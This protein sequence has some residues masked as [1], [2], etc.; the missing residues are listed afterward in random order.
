MFPTKRKAPRAVPDQNQK[1]KTRESYV[2][3]PTW[4]FTNQ[5]PCLRSSEKGRLFG[6]TLILTGGLIAAVLGGPSEAS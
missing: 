4:D 2:I 1:A 3:Q 6:R 5:T